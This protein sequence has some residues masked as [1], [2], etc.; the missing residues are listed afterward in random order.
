MKKLLFLV[1][2]ILALWSQNL[3]AQAQTIVTNT[4][5]WLVYN[6]TGAPSAGW[7][8]TWP[9]SGWVAPILNPC[10]W[11]PTLG[12][13]AQKIVHPSYT[14]NTLNT[15]TYYIRQFNMTRIDNV[16]SFWNS[17]LA[18]DVVNLWINGHQII[19]NFNGA[20]G[21]TNT[22][23]T[24]NRYFLNCGVNIIAAQVENTQ[25]GCFFLENI[26]SISTGIGPGTTVRNLTCANNCTTLDMPNIIG[27][28]PGDPN[29]SVW[30]DGAT[31]SVRT[32]CIP[33]NGLYRCTTSYHGCSMVRN[34]QINVNNAFT[35]TG[36]ISGQNMASCKDYYVPFSINN[37]QN[38]PGLTYEWNIYPAGP[39]VYPDN[40][41]AYVD[42]SNMN[43]N[44][45]YT[46]KC[47]VNYNGCIKIIDK[48]ITLRCDDVCV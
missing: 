16:T 37:P 19:T 46:L 22:V 29:S 1:I 33:D 41:N 39:T 36:S 6:G 32:F 31:G 44:G 4:T 7:Q 42:F 43:M 45:S 11:A 13:G 23:S 24:I 38:L 27:L 15:T 18:D 30:S 5:D 9:T 47:T 2:S 17:C 12:S 3:N 8:T 35:F 10:G 40:E 21:I 14:G 20:G 26:M 34:V 25:V 48:P 28:V